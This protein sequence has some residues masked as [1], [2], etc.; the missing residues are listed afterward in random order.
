MPLSKKINICQSNYE[1]LGVKVAELKNEYPNAV[2]VVNL[3]WGPEHILQPTRDQIRQGR[4]LIDQGADLIIGHHPHVIQSKEV[5]KGKE[6][7]YSLGNF[8]FDQMTDLNSPALMVKVTVV[9]GMIETE[10]I[11]YWI[12]DC[13]PERIKR[14]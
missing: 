7:Y 10:A 8:I 1:E 9:E 3:H 2:L 14:D 5:Y 11:D 13:K 4:H 6:I 12:E